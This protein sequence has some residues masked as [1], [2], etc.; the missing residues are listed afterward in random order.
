MAKKEY[1]IPPGK[2][3]T[4]RVEQ[5]KWAAKDPG[6]PPPKDRSAKKA[7]SFG[8]ITVTIFDKSKQLPIE[9]EEEIRSDLYLFPDG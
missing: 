8:T 3:Q 9:I 4:A 5:L 6:L 7:C 2:D 1:R